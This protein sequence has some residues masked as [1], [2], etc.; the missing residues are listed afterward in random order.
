MVRGFLLIIFALFID[1]LQFMIS[2]SFLA[3]GTSWAAATP[4]GGGVAGAA[5][6]AAACW[7]ASGGIISGIT[8]A[9]KCA[10]AGGVLGAVGSPFGTVIGPALGVIVNFAL[11]ATLGTGLV[12]LLAMNG[13]FYPWRVFPAYLGELLPAINNLPTWTALVLMCLFKKETKEIVHKVVD[14]RPKEPARVDGIGPAKQ[15]AQVA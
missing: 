4:V 2:L 12:F 7:S 14:S 6:G 10:A 9:A 5:A 15:H 11:S 1:G 13:M 8:E 3:L